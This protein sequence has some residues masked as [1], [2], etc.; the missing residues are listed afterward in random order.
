MW[1]LRLLLYCAALMFSA[2]AA[3]EEISFSATQKSLIA[4]FAPWPDTVPADAGNEYSGSAWAQKLG[5]QLFNDP[6][7]SSSQQI[8]CA[9]CHQ[10]QHGLADGD[11]VAILG[12][13]AHVRN[14]QGLH[15][16]GMQRWFGWDGGA[17]S[18]WAASLRPIL[19]D[20]EMASSI[21]PLAKRLRGTSY[22]IDTL[23]NNNIDTRGWDDETLMVSVA[24]FLGAYM[25]TLVS[26]ETPF[27]EFVSALLRGDTTQSNYSASAQRG[28]KLFFGEGNCFVCHFGPNFSNG[29]F[30]DIGRPFFTGVGQVDPGR[31]SGIQRLKSDR[32]SLVGPFNGTNKESD[33]LKTRTVKSGQVNFGQWRTPSLR[34]LKQTAPYMHD[35]SLETLRDVIDYY[36]DID[37]DRLHSKGESILKPFNWTDVQRED[38]VEFLESL[39]E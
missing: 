27:D 10:S 14:T 11:P 18:L 24:K 28:M 29:E 7:L 12:S 19:S 30:H 5:A 33:K 1:V 37:V 15:N 6:V 13:Q 8:S 39:S 26:G 20:I 38:L 25:R 34:N 3:G 31:F 23:E 21:E 22:L 35:G 17:D 36:A 4:S 2:T 16:V 32:Y 9:T